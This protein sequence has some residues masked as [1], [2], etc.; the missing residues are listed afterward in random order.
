MMAPKLL[1][2]KRMVTIHGK[3][4][5]CAFI[6]AEIEPVDKAKLLEDFANEPLFKRVAYA[7]GF[8]DGG[9]QPSPALSRMLSNF[10]KND[11][12][13]EIT[14][15][16]ILAGQRFEGAGIWDIECFVF[17]AKRAF[18]ALAEVAAG[19]RTFETEIAYFGFG[20]SDDL[21]AF[22]AD[23]TAELVASPLAVAPASIEGMADAA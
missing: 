13:P 18:D 20:V 15:R 21:V 4:R 12:C 10:V 3:A 1:I 5:P 6:R 22:A 14:V 17:I 23:T 11:A 19:V 7:N 2:A 8:A 9:A 16:T